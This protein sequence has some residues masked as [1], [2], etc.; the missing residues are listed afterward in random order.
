MPKYIDIEPL[1]VV[2]YTET[3]GMENTFDSGVQWIMEKI[4]RLPAADV[5]PVVHSKWIIEFSGNG[6]NDWYNC[7]CP[8]CM[9]KFEKFDPTRFCPNCG[10]KMDENVNETEPVQGKQI[11]EYRNSVVEE[12]KKMGASPDEIS[13]LT[14]ETIIRSLSL[15]RKPEDVAWAL[16]E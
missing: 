6:W 14:Y 9:V 10:A 2:S 15:D 1:D 8:V 11:V 3:E 4:D 13:L 12:M 16:L 5:L 7:T